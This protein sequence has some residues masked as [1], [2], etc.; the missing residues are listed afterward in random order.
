MREDYK[1]QKKIT[2]KVL[3]KL[4]GFNEEQRKV[5]EEQKKV[6]ECLSEMLNALDARTGPMIL[7]N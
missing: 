2:E 1:E 4:K 5:N 3:R 7:P 6:N